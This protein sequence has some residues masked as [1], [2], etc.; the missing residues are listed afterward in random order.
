MRM[1][2]RVGS[3]TYYVSKGQQVVRQAQ[4]NSNYGESASRTEAQ[5]S[6]RV[7]WANV[8]NFYKA[9]AGWMK[10]AFE[11]KKKGQTD[12]N[13]LM[14]VN[15]GTANIFLTRDE[16]EAGCC[17]IAPFIVSQGSLPSISIVQSG[18]V[19]KTDIALGALVLGADTSVADFSQAVIMNNKTWRELDQLSFISYQQN[20]DAFGRP[21]TICT[22]YEV[23]LNLTDPRTLRS[24]LPDFCSSQTADGYLATNENISLGGFTYVQSRNA[25]NSR[26]QVSSQQLINNNSEMIAQYSSAEQLSAA[27]R[28]YGLSGSSFLDS[29]S[30]QTNPTP[31]P[32]FIQF[33]TSGS[34]DETW[35]SEA[36]SL[37][38]E[39]I[40]EDGAFNVVMAVPVALADI[41]DIRVKFN[42]DDEFV[43]FP[44]TVVW[45]DDKVSVDGDKIIL[46]RV[47]VVPVSTFLQEVE[48]V[49]KGVTYK[50]ALSPSN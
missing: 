22:A 44:Q 30:E 13:K 45:S 5:Q 11:A 33:L 42:P 40:F 28:S 10:K 49:I 36:R 38:V 35:T 3:M 27:I 47:N 6:N 31:Q 8:V 43:A 18:A 14:S 9:S 20:V 29:G 16:A 17:I 7:K 25:T 39:H 4:N 37:D 34:G 15:L 46:S 24:F 41:S 32:N 21:R 2:G 19:W 12:Y 50:Y 48:L 1:A 23:T 26:L